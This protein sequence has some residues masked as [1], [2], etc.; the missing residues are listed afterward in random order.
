MK[1]AQFRRTIDGSHYSYLTILSEED[2]RT[3]VYAHGYTRVTEWVEVEFPPRDE[4]EYVP[5]H[6]AQLDSAESE[7][8][9]K[10]QQKLSEIS[11]ERAKLRALT[12]QS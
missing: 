2:S 5:E 3:S 7:L 10:F 8:R 12:V 1:L 4:R 6:L 9:S 11:L